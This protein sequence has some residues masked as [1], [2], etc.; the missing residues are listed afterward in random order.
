MTSSKSP[1]GTRGPQK[2][3][4]RVCAA[5][6]AGSDA[7]AAVKTAVRA[8]ALTIRFMQ[9]TFRAGWIEGRASLSVSERFGH[10]ANTP[11]LAW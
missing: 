2:R 1:N 11:S 3:V 5:L 6:G 9:N 10:R 8:A 4:R 7:S